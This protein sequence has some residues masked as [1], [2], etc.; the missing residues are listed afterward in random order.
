MK[1]FVRKVIEVKVFPFVELIFEEL[2]FEGFNIFLD[3]EDLVAD[4]IGLAKSSIFL[5]YFSEDLAFD[6]II[7]SLAAE[8][9]EDWLEFFFEFEFFAFIDVFLVHDFWAKDE[10]I[11]SW[12]KS[13]CQVEFLF[14]SKFSGSESGVKDFG[15]FCVVILSCFFGFRVSVSLVDSGDLEVGFLVDLVELS[16][17]FFEWLFEE[18]SF[19]KE[20]FVVK[21][22]IE[23]FLFE[24]VEDIGVDGAFAS[25][26][27][28][29]IDFFGDF[30]VGRV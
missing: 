11:L 16:G 1:F 20:L 9:I 2:I 24:F 17:G 29:E 25:E 19:D 23:V 10:D 5:W 21:L 22:N 15:I 4:L 27:A 28:D 26:S 14:E 7:K 13:F 18:V 6:D 12:L 8:V 3:G 30:E